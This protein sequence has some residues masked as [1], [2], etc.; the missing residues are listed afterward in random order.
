MNA[1]KFN[2]L[3]LSDPIHPGEI[4]HE[5]FMVPLGL[6]QNKLAVSLGV[7]PRRIN[8]IVNAKRGITAETAVLFAAFFGTTEYYW[9]NLQAY[10]ELET[11][12]AVIRESAMAMAF[13]DVHDN[14]PGPGIKS[15]RSVPITEKEIVLSEA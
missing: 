8:E 13:P 6:S 12:D 2:K 11:V 5:E 14:A 1:E 9:M 4:L 15:K 3:P 10:Y 7:S